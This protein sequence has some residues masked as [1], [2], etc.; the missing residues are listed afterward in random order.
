MAT[1]NGSE[2]DDNVFAGSNADSISG[3]GGNDSIDGG[4][5]NDT[6]DGGAGSDT[7]DGEGGNDSL[8]GGAGNDEIV[9]GAGDDTLIGGDGDD[10]LIDDADH[11]SM[12]GGD[13]NDELYANG[14]GSTLDGGA[15]SDTIAGSSEEDVIF[16]GADNDKIYANEGNDTVDGGDGH[17]RI[18][19]GKGDDVI[20]G[21]AGNDTI[22]A[23]EGKNTLEG[24]SGNDTLVGGKDEDSIH[25]G[26]GADRIDGGDGNDTLV[27]GNGNDTILAREGD[28]NLR[29]GAGNDELYA[30]SGKNTLEGGEGDD[31]LFSGSGS[32][33]FVIRDGHGNDTIFGFNPATDKVAFDMNEMAT[34]QDVLNRMT[35]D[36]SDT[37]ITFD[38]GDVLRFS[39]KSPGQF[40]SSNF[41][42]SAGPVCL[43]AGTPILT[44][45]G[46][47]PIEELRPDDILWTK[48]HGW[49][50]IRLVVLETMVFKHRNDRSKPVLIPAGALG[51]DSPQTDLIVSP[52][53]RILHV[54][55][56][57]G[58]E[59][60][61]PAIKLVGQNGTRQMR[62]RKKALYLNVVMERHSIIQAAGC[63]VESM[64]VTRRSLSRQT[65][66]ARRLLDHCLG[67]EPARRVEK[68]GIRP[69]RLKAT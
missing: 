17:D 29:G 43:H 60:L 47:I 65:Q 49:Q 69:R 18:E 31:S 68:K 1:I 11:S 62:G 56:G 23:S 55:S 51:P 3:N 15:G 50:A 59:V 28:D 39:G 53:H 34:Y 37:L 21:G 5:G 13:G 42:Y 20:T 16:G 57:S 64:L 40:S 10:T 46:N 67:M 38:N 24:G 45:R 14:K 63:W 9:G 54:F 19:G 58:E 25:G 41:A 32:D 22:T 48:D 26:S 36:G 66:S 8:S 33:T 12:S 4:D 44:E 2:G 30:M 35:Q 6:I 61:V 52:Q 7:I 27:G